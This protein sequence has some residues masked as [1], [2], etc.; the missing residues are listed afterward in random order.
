MEKV[1]WGWDADQIHRQHPHLPLSKIHA[2]FSYYDHQAE[3]DAEVDRIDRDVQKM[4]PIAVPLPPEKF[5][6]AL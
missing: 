1:A 4:P 3:M 2:A 6:S 5:F